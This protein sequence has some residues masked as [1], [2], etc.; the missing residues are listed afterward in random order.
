MVVIISI[1]IMMQAAIR[2][3]YA[4]R[5]YNRLQKRDI[6]GIDRIC[7]AIRVR[8]CIVNCIYLQQV[9]E[10]QDGLARGPK[11]DQRLHDRQDLALVVPLAGSQGSK[12]S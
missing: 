5:I 6:Y 7:I 4:R 3:Y 8:I 10:A 9:V 12:T 2:A 11:D 1:T